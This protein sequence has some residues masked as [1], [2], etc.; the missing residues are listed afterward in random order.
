M[1]WSKRQES[2]T[3]KGEITP[4]VLSISGCSLRREVGCLSAL[5][6]QHNSPTGFCHKPYEVTMEPQSRASHLFHAGH[7]IHSRKHTVELVKYRRKYACQENKELELQASLP[8]PKESRMSPQHERL[9][10]N[11]E[12]RRDSWPPEERT[13]LDC[14]ELLCNKVL[15]KYKRDR[16]SF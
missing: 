10:L 14:S 12:R 2:L 8:C 4:H 1:K 13:R 3:K 15:L 5:A 16:E 9:L 7:V 6:G 11:H